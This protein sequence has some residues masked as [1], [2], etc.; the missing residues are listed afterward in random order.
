M[1]EVVYHTPDD[2]ITTK[3]MRVNCGWMYVHVER[4]MAGK[5]M[6]SVFV[7]DNYAFKKRYNDV[8]ER[9]EDHDPPVP[10]RSSV[11]Y[12]EIR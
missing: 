12:S 3:R 7:P 2:N 11:V 5:Q 6:T 9:Y 8:T 1:W 10:P 4:F